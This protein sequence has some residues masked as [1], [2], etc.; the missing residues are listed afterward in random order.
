M[1]IFA[2]RVPN[3]FMILSIRFSYIFIANPF[4]FWLF[5]QFQTSVSFALSSGYFLMIQSFFKTNFALFLVLFRQFAIQLVILSY[6]PNHIVP[7]RDFLSRKRFWTLYPKW[8]NGER[9]VGIV[10]INPRYYLGFVCSIYRCNFQC[11]NMP[12]ILFLFSLLALI[13]FREALSICKSI[14]FYHW[15]PRIINPLKCAFKD[16]FSRIGAPRNFTTQI[17]W[18]LIFQ[19]NRSRIRLFKHQLFSF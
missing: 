4:F 7:W 18:V 9:I 15:F 2:T 3:W 12:K 16:L 17:S 11:I 8:I 14:P 6:S 1:Q 19:S 5:S 10:W 13:S